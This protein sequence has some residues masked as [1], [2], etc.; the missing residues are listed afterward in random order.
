MGLTYTQA[1]VMSCLE[2]PA[3]PDAGRPMTENLDLVRSICAPWAQGDFSS[4]EWADPNIEYAHVDGPSP[5]R[6]IAVAAMGDAFREVLNAYAGYEVVAE[7][8][9]ELD[10]ER[11]LVLH[12]YNGRGR[13]SKIEIAQIASKGADLFHISHGRVTKLI[14]YWQLRRAFADLGL[15]E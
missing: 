14:L 12:R 13:T 5:G 8:Y 9:R 11:I 10:H 1:P 6:W 15:T 7:E 3:S 2:G 4:T